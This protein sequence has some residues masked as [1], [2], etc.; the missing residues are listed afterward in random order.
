MKNELLNKDVNIY[1]LIASPFQPFTSLWLLEA[2][3]VY[4]SLKDMDP[5]HSN[6]MYKHKI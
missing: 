6:N 3:H 5:A 4:I 2:R 1:H